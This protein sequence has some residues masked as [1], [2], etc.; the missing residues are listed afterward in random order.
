M[1]TPLSISH[2]VNKNVSGLG[3]YNA[4]LSVDELKAK[5]QV[6][7]VAKLG[8]NENPFPTSIAV[9]NVLQEDDNLGHYPDPYCKSLTKALADKLAVPAES[10]VVGNG[11]E[12]LIGIISRVFIEPGDKVMT[13]VPSFG[14]HILYPK[15][16]GATVLIAEMTAQLKFDIEKIVTMLSVE[17]PKL[18][19]IASPSNPVGCSL[20]Q[21]DI[22]AILHHLSDDTLLVFD[23]AYYEYAKDDA[24][25][26]D[27]LSILKASGKPFVLLRTFSKAYSL[28]GLRVGYG[29]FYPT[30]LADYTHKLRTPF[31]VN[32]IAQKAAVVALSDDAHLSKTMAWNRLAR[33]QMMSELIALGLSPEVSKGNYLFFATDWHGTE[34]AKRLLRYG[35]IVK[36]WLEEGYQQYIRVSIG[37]EMENQ[38]FITSL[39]EILNSSNEV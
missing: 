19:F 6:D 35:V 21:E 3:A 13:V 38:L 10:I 37:T 27:V 34:L 1:K 7:Q 36:P 11:S 24:D 18:F 33:D 26:P 25:Y 22:K 32:R 16:C 5:Y 12:D 30:A 31:N 8:S 17:K 39:R 14:L 20:N 2:L 15:A 29:V 23:E 4:G 28:A 9:T